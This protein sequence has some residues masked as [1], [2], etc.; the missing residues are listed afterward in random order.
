MKNQDNQE[1]II[2]CQ[3]IDLDRTVPRNLDQ[4]TDKKQTDF[5]SLILK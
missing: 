5:T 2:N 3:N 4:K 1:M